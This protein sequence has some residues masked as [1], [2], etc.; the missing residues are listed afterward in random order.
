MK[1]SVDEKSKKTK[2][3]MESEKKKEKQ[4]NEI[5]DT[6]WMYVDLCISRTALHGG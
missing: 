5:N 2:K 3:S 4:K 6:K 1:E